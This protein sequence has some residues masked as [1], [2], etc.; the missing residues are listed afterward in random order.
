MERCVRNGEMFMYLVCDF[1][2]KWLKDLNFLFCISILLEN[3][4]GKVVDI[5]Q[6][7]CC[8]L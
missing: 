4:E 2:G 3:V 7:G 6:V 1:N 8:A 5:I